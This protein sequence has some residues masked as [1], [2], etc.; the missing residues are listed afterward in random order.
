M[1]KKDRILTFSRPRERQS[2]FPARSPE[3]LFRAS[4]G[5][6]GAVPLECISQLGVNEMRITIIC[7]GGRHHDHQGTDR[8]P[9][10]WVDD[11]E[12]RQALG[13]RR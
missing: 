1:G 7:F 4:A 9:N 2:F 11:H 6:F 8:R 12:F 3:I 5:E 13:K 10:H